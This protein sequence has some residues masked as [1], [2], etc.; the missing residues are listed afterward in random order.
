VLEPEESDPDEEALPFKQNLKLCNWRNEPQNIVSDTSSELTV[1]LHKHATIALVGSFHFKVLRGA[2]NINGANIGALSRDDNKDQVYTAYVPATHPIS[3][4][5]GLD[6]ANQVQFSN[7]QEPAPLAN[8]GPLFADIW[9][10]QET[11]EKSRTF[12]VVCILYVL[13]SQ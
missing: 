9:S 12:S 5:R 1:K 6:G 2:V 10:A 7:C 3:K 8:I 11:G 4:I 13:R